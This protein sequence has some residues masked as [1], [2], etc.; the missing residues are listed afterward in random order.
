MP[1][2][3]VKLRLLLGDGRT[4]GPGKAELLTLIAQLG[5]ITAAGREMEMSYK[6]AWGL[7]EEMNASFCE[8]LVTTARGGAGH[9][10]AQVTELGYEV[11]SHYR[12]LVGAVE[13]AGA[14]DLEFIALS[15]SL[16]KD[17]L[18]GPEDTVMFTK[19]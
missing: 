13:V 15:L 6:R 7:V 14:N 9:G 8:A 16:G 19:T 3:Q 12:N 10:G 4:F 2:P 17:D 5:S 18:P 11:L 1:R